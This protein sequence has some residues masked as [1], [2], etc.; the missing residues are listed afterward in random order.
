MKE[1]LIA[2]L[3]LSC[4]FSLFFYYKVYSTSDDN[5]SLV[6][7]VTDTEEVVVKLINEIQAEN[8]ELSDSWQKGVKQQS[9]NECL[10]EQNQ[11]D[12]LV[13]ANAFKY[14]R[15]C[16]GANSTFIWNTN[17][18]STVLA[19]EISDIPELLTN[20]DTKKSD[21]NI[22]DIHYNLQKEMTGVSL[23]TK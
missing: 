4:V 3:T 8:N 23:D 21:K 10:L 17:E 7:D 18:Y 19:S 1:R 14:Y 13:F 11:T 9:D 12:E 22:D 15:N 2:F 20:E 16:N 6:N 5:F